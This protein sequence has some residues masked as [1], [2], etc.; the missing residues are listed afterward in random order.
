[1]DKQSLTGELSKQKQINAK[2]KDKVKHNEQQ[3]KKVNN[4]SDDE[5]GKILAEST[6]KLENQLKLVT[7]LKSDKEQLNKKLKILDDK[8]KY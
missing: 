8:L 7:M 5:I 6:A 2:L 3:L 4:Q 1:M